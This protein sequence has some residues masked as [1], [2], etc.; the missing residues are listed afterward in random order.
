MLDPDKTI[1][2]GLTD[3]LSKLALELALAEP[4]KDT[5]LLPINCFIIQVADQVA[6]LHVPTPFREAAAVARQWLDVIFDSTA[7]FDGPTIARFT[8]WHGWMETAIARW[9]QG[10]ALPELSAELNVPGKIDRTPKK[11]FPTGAPDAVA[12]TTP[13]PADEL[14]LESDRDLFLE[15]VNESQEHLQNIENGVLVLEDNPTDADTLNSIFRAFHTFKGGAGFLSLTA[16]TNLAHELESLLDAARQHKL[17][18]TSE[19]IEI[20]LAGSDTLKQFVVEIT[21]QLNGKNAGQPMVVPTQ[22]IIA[23][24]KAVL[25]EDSGIAAETSTTLRARSSLSVCNDSAAAQVSE[26]RDAS[27]VGVGEF[28]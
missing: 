22:H 25:L 23:K 4:C 13:E 3:L 5:G 17:A 2:T 20:I 9:R 18:I 19:V 6:P 10:L 24:V 16:I 7:V 12:G 27:K 8:E 1:T 15:F 26:P 14:N 11:N 28:G 21:A